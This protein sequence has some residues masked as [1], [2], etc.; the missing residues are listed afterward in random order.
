MTKEEKVKYYELLLKQL[1]AM[2]KNESDWLANTANASALLFTTMKEINWAGFYM[3]KKDELVLGAFQGKPACIRITIGKGVCGTSAKERKTIV[4]SDVHK[5]EGHIACDCAS[6][7]EI[8]VPIIKENI[9]IGVLDID[10]P[11][12]ARFDEI[13][14]NYLEKFIKILNKYCIW[15]I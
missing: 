14:A 15:D 12:F 6:N 10:S 1:E 11:N 8:V 7:S 5:F 3:Y 4:V 2:I 13:D 9:L